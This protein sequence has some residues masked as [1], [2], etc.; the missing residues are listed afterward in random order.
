MADLVKLDDNNRILVEQGLRR[1]RSGKGC[2][3]IRALLKLA[4][5]DASRVSAQDLGF[6]VGPRLNAAGRLDD[7]SLGIACLLADDQV[8]AQRMAQKLHEL[9]LAR[10]S[11]EADMQDTADNAL[12]DLD[13][14][15]RYSLSL[16][17]PEW[18]Q[19]VVGILASRIKER[20]HRPVIAFAQAG[21]GTLK[22]SGRSIS[23]LH[24]RD[25]LDL[26]SKRQ[27]DLMIRFGGHAMAA[28]L[29]IQEADFERFNAEF[30]VVVAGLLTLT[31]LEAIIEV[32]G[33]L[34]A[35]DIHWD[36]A[37][38]I[39]RQVWGQG[40]PQPA[41]CD[42]FQVIDQRVVGERH[43]KLTLSKQGKRFDAIFFQQRE[44]LPKD[45]LA[46]YHLQTNEYK[47]AQAVQ[48]SLR[49][50]QALV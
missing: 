32:D 34:D 29:T 49:H 23:G 19:G 22:G 25:A 16:Y 36:T 11:I 50:W 5:R 12:E 7:M 30:E 18:H 1:I 39:E 13:P 9:N 33:G 44:F 46:V 4:G 10:R 24:L 17:Q 38:A 3:G 48:L 45:I 41:F 14:A 27:P 20:Y 26:L 40:F 47:G 37:C 6:S 43:L 2:A 28:G 31:D 21:D 42:M 35:T 8:E 15:G